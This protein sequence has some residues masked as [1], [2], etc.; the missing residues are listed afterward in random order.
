[1]VGQSP[2]DNKRG[3]RFRE[4]LWHDASLAWHEIDA[5]LPSD[6]LARVIERGVMSLDLAPLRAA[7]K[8]TG[9]PA[10]PPERLLAVVLYDMQCKRLSPSQWCQDARENLPVRWLLRGLTPSRT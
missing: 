1:M 3:P 2:G 10:Y 6:H 5:K 7:Y 9:S 4:I 8:G